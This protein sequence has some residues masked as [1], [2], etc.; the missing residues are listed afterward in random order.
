MISR[1]GIDVSS[2]NH[3]GDAR[4]DFVAVKEAGYDFVMIKA[5]QALDYVNPFLAEDAVEAHAAGMLVGVYHFAVPGVGDAQLQALHAIAAIA[6]LPLSLGIA[7]DL[8]ESGNLQV[9]E[10]SPWAEE[11]LREI[12]TAGHIASI[13]VDESYRTQ[14]T[15]IPWG[16]HL[17]CASP[18]IPADVRPWLHQV[19]E[20]SVPGVPGLVDLDVMPSSR[21]VNPVHRPLAGTPVAVERPK[22]DEQ[23]TQPPES[24]NAATGPT[25]GA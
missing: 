11:F 20:G 24:V 10:L 6:H 18:T 12:R 7:L 21:G 17:W 2:W 15:G 22:P 8:E 5:T 16:S 25:G 1:K 14:L 9:Y 3:E 19:G 13:Y 4:I 23:D